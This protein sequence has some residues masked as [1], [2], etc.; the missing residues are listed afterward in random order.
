[1]GLTDTP[2]S[3]RVH[4]GIFGHTNAGKSSLI[5]ALT[6][7]KTS[8]VSDIEGTTTD[9][10]FKAIELFP[11]GPCVLIDTPG[12]N[13]N[14]ILGKERI[15]KAFEVLGKTDVALIVVDGTSIMGRAEIALINEINV[16]KLPYLII[17]NKADKMTDIDKKRIES[18]PFVKGH[19]FLVSAKFNERIDELKT[20]IGNMFKGKIR[21]D[22]MLSD[23]VKKDDVIVLVTPI[24]E[25]APKGRMILPQQ[26]AI[27]DVLHFKGITMVVEP[28]ELEAAIKS[29]KNPPKLI[30]TDSQAFAKVGAIVPKNIPLTSFSILLARINYDLNYLVESAKSLKNIKPDDTILISEGCTHHRQCGDIGAVKIPALIK[31]TLGFEPKIRLTSGTDFASALDGVKLIIHCGGCML[32]DKELEHRMELSKEKGIKMTNYGIMIAYMTGILDRAV[33]PLL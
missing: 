21:E 29:L 10:V 6:G 28:D 25:S 3:E 11:I 32:N 9:P 26:Q 27:R 19:Y 30:V 31:K 14:S 20:Y 18:D 4:I 7:Q 17:V 13:D 8:I 33:A 24:D 2:R 15:T 5:N 1:M 12:L 16:R 22:H 23:L